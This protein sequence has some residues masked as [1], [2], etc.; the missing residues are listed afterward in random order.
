MVLE[1]EILVTWVCC[2]PQNRDIH[3]NIS[4]ILSALLRKQM[5][6][7]LAIFLFEMQTKELAQTWCVLKPKVH[8]KSQTCKL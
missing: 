1:K 7:I 6:G 2:T 3:R 4:A 5:T 8:K